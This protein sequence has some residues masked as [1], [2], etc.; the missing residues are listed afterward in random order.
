MNAMGFPEILIGIVLFLLITALTF[1]INPPSV[2]LDRN[3]KK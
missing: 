2:W 1:L 3:K